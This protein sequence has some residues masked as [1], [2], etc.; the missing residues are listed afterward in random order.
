MSTVTGR[1]YGRSQLVRSGLFTRFAAGQPLLRAPNTQQGTILTCPV[2][3]LIYSL[4]IIYTAMVHLTKVSILY[5]YLQF[6]PFTVFPKLR[7]AIYATM[8]VTVLMAIS[9]TITM[10]FQCTPINSFWDRFN[11]DIPLSAQASWTCINLPVYGYTGAALQLV[12]DLW[13]MALPM[14]ELLRLSLPLRKKLVVCF[15]FAVGSL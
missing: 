1:T 15:M 2:G 13:L 9:F 10:T 14:P 12:L 3:K 6:F 7:T 11:E 4:Q 5:F 8:V